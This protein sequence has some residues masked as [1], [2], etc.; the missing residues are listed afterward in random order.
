VG[1]GSDFIA[2]H[3]AAVSAT[4]STDQSWS[5]RMARRWW[6]RLMLP[7]WLN[8]PCARTATASRTVSVTRTE[9]AR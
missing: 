6:L 3:T 4:E 7:R 8:G 5:H 9:V 2:A 1:V